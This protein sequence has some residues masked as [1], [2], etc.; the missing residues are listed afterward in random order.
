M[1]IFQLRPERK[2]WLWV[3]T[4]GYTW[5]VL[6]SPPKMNQFLY[7]DGKNWLYIV[8][9]WQTL[10]FFF[11]GK[12]TEWTTYRSTCQGQP[13]EP[14][15]L[16]SIGSNLDQRGLGYPAITNSPRVNR[17]SSQSI[18][19]QPNTPCKSMRPCFCSPFRQIFAGPTSKQLSFFSPQ[20]KSPNPQTSKNSSSTP[21]PI[22]SIPSLPSQTHHT[23]VPNASPSPP[24]ATPSP[25]T[26]LRSPRSP[27]RTPTLPRLPGRRPTCETF[28]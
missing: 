27:W 1:I 6:G 21:E 24:A 28:G 9:F 11:A 26:P 10:V 16:T 8:A 23:S 2:T 14:G 12:R 13:D 25:A 20:Q 5:V 19:L 4:L 22:P 17:P 7:R 3:M 15:E 18:S